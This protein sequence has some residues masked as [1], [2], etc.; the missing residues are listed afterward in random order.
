MSVT[1]NELILETLIREMSEY[2]ELRFEA[3][4]G[5]RVSKRKEIRVP[6]HSGKTAT[7]KNPNYNREKPENGQK[8]RIPKESKSKNEEWI[9]PKSVPFEE[10]LLFYLSSGKYANA[11][12]E[13]KK[14]IAESGDESYDLF[15]N[16]G[17]HE[18][19]KI[20]YT[21]MRKECVEEIPLLFA[22]IGEDSIRRYFPRMIQSF[23]V[24]DLEKVVES[25]EAG[26]GSI[27]DFTE[28]PFVKR[29]LNASQDVL[30]R[31]IYK[32]RRKEYS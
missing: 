9:L 30:R 32:K 27:G 17:Y 8:E 31:A 14:K 20:L 4:S 7:P 21:C 12:E 26:R 22:L 5:S 6:P 23:S 1:Q 15:E 25:V 13:M 19:L 24:G 2:C 10:R 11:A 28:K 16:V 3:E 29:R 18:T